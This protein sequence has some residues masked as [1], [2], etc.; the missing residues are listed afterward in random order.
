MSLGVQTGL[1]DVYQ[2]RGSVIT[3][4]IVT[5]PQ[6]SRAAPPLPPGVGSDKLSLLKKYELC[7]LLYFS[8]WS[9]LICK[10][11]IFP[12]ITVYLFLV[13]VKVSG[14]NYVGKNGAG[15]FFWFPIKM[16]K[17]VFDKIVWMVERFLY[18]WF[19]YFTQRWTIPN[20]A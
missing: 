6:M 19:F 16:V 3:S 17:L 12:I 14:N 10:V 2:V 18:I 20:L 7:P 5:M 9:W 1:I 4:Q 15:K 11:F 8:F 13:D